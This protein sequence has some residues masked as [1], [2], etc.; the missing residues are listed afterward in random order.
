V[1]DSCSNSGCRKHCCCSCERGAPLR[2]RTSRPLVSKVP[3]DLC[4]SFTSCCSAYC[5]S[6]LLHRGC[7][8]PLPAPR[9]LRALAFRLCFVLLFS[10]APLLLLLLIKSNHPVP[11]NKDSSSQRR[12]QL[13]HRCPCRHLV[14]LAVDNHT[15]VGRAAAG[16]TLRRS[17]TAAVAACRDVALAQ[18]SM[19]RQ[20][21]VYMFSDF[22]PCHFLRA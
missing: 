3:I 11:R 7:K 18:E 9:S 17:R 5:L 1:S 13:Q 21:R 10:C 15:A 20:G 8:Y 4:T 12:G 19:F 2:W 22:G 6:L 16:R 14:C